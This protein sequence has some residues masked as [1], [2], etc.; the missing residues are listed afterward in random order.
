MGLKQV[1]VFAPA[2]SWQQ[3]KTKVTFGA[4]FDE[5]TE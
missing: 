2:A 3:R 5:L 4:A 1:L